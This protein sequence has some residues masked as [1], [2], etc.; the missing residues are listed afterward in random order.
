MEKDV[1]YPSWVDKK[2]IQDILKIIEE[3]RGAWPGSTG[4]MSLNGLYYSLV[5]RNLINRET[6]KMDD[7]RR[8]VKWMRDKNSD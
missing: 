3:A 4:R 2:L 1:K 7:V 6:C 5:E 8:T